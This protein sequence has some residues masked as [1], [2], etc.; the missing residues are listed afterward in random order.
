MLMLKMPEILICCLGM[1]I[2][3]QIEGALYLV[4]HNETH[5]SREELYNQWE[6]KTRLPEVLS[7]NHLPC[8][9]TKSKH[10]QEEVKNRLIPWNL[11]PQI[12]TMSLY[13]Y[14]CRGDLRH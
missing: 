6:F 12:R 5:Q 11:L 13:Y 2:N 7:L 9:E 1:I 14:I 10:S 4:V 8:R 3:W